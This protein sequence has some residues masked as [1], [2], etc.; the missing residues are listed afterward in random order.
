MDIYWDS[1]CIGTFL[2][3][4]VQLLENDPGSAENGSESSKFIGPT[5]S[6]SHHPPQGFGEPGRPGLHPMCRDL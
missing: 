4:F 6:P 5:G 1:G 2:S 3:V